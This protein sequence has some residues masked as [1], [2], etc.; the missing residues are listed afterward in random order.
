MG[1]K[2]APTYTTQTLAYLEE[3]LYEIIGKKYNVKRNIKGSWKRYLNDGF[4]FWKYQWGNINKLLNLFQNL[5]PKIKWTME[6]SFKEFPFLDIPSKNK[7]GQIITDIYHRPT[8]PPL[9]LSPLEK[10]HKIYPLHS[11][12]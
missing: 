10:L 12:T 7:N 2:M 3:N 5:H 9:Q 1:T 11:N 6:H 8:T 4:I